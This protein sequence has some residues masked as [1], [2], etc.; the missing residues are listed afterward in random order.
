MTWLKLKWAVALNI[1]GGVAAAV[2]TAFDI[3]YLVNSNFC[4]VASGCSYLSYTFSA[5]PPYY[6][7]QTILGIFFLISGYFFLLT[8][9]YSN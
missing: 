1:L 9:Y 3:L 5:V 2:M 8:S 7:G 4:L 6:T